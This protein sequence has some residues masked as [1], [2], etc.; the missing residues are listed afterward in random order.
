[1][2]AVLFVLA[3]TL[4]LL[5]GLLIARQAPA[6]NHAAA[7]PYRA[8]VPA[9]ARDEPSGLHTPTPGPEVW[10]IE[11]GCYVAPG[12]TYTVAGYEV[13]QA[14]QDFYYA[15]AVAT[16]Q[17]EP[18][19]HTGNL[20][21]VLSGPGSFSEPASAF[22]TGGVAEGWFSAAANEGIFS[23]GDYQLALL[24]GPQVAPGSTTTFT[25]PGD[26]EPLPFDRFLAGTFPQV[27][28]FQATFSQGNCPGF[29]TTLELTL[30]AGGQARF[31]QP[32]TGDLNEGHYW[33][34]G[35]PGSNFRLFVFNADEPEAYFGLLSTNLQTFSGQAT[36][37][38]QCLWQVAAVRGY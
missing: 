25:I 18:F 23:E 17:G 7:P 27:H 34:A 9:L 10:L 8:V 26:C 5:G 2:R 32:D 28:V 3:A 13:S 24:N 6:S 30:S 22:A 19:I 29:A 16:Y 4:T 37:K 20:D 11:A 1:M 38:E 35:P 31:F 21:F 12:H 33:P 36:W 15:H 14:P